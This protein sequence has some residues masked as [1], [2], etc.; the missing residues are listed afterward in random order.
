MNHLATL[1]RAFQTF[2][3][4]ADNA[5]QQEVSD[6]PQAPASE[7]LGIYSTAY[8]LRL[9]EALQTDYTALHAA[10][11]DEGFEQLCFAFIDAFPSTYP[12]L[13]WFGAN[14]DAYLE[15]TPPYAD[16]PVLAEL[17]R[18]EWAKGLAFDAPDDTFL[19]IQE[20]ASIPVEN[21]PDMAFQ[22]HASVQRLDLFSNA[23]LIWKAV[24]AE[25]E[26]PQPAY[27]DGPLA[28]IIWRHDLKVFFRSLTVDEAWAI[29]NLQH[30]ACFAEI[31]TG[32]CEWVDE[33]HA[34][35]HAAGLLKGW[36][37]SGMIRSVQLKT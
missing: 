32:L 35:Q 12:N 21:W 8:R 31:C 29:D 30:G 13:R 34:A 10:L 19:S 7:R 18:F 15:T 37:E 23:P 26:P 6:T 27:S 20:I 22:T 33:I 3:L 17:A 28:W 2:I 14:L 4:N 5:I 16:I 9:L 24:A 25:Q 11:G 36:V 1:Q